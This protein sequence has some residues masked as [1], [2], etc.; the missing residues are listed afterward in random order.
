MGT[1]FSSE[2][3]DI[4]DYL[5][6]SKIRTFHAGEIVYGPHQASQDLFLIVEGRVQVSRNI[7]P[8]VRI[9]VEIYGAEEF[10]GESALLGPARCPEIAMALEDSKLMS[11][12]GDRLQAGM[13]KK[14]EVAI[15][16]AQI[17]ALRIQNAGSRL[18]NLA[19]YHVQHRLLHAL[20][21]LGGR[22]G[23]PTGARTIEITGL[24]RELLAEYTAASRASIGYW[25]NSLQRHGLVKYSGNSVLLYL[26]AIEPWLEPHPPGNARIPA[27][28][29][30]RLSSAASQALSH[31]ERQIMELVATGL[32]NRQ[33]AQHLSIRA[34][35]VK[36]HLHTIFEKLKVESR[37]QAVLRLASKGPQRAGTSAHG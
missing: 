6:H 15:A 14:P 24:D 30:N 31:R 16:L 10:F 19:R 1:A 23:R 20:I 2:R 37:Q 29:E 17:L 11:W 26:D 18:E 22:L 21:H 7:E 3:L 25:M 32:T 33:V 4:L 34:Q 5:P 12:T 28:T 36:N 13:R 27:E 9:V 8:G 35:T